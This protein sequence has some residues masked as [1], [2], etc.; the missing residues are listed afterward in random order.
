MALS[1]KDRKGVALIAAVVLALAAIVAT[2]LAVGTAPKPGPDGCVGAVVANTVVVLDHTETQ[3]EQTRTEVVARVLAHVRDKTQVNER[4]SVFTVSELSKKSLTP[5][6]SRCKPAE[7]GNR[8]VQNVSALKKA[9]D[10]D[11]LHPLRS[12]LSIPP[13]SGKE[14]PIA[15]ALIDLSLTQYLRGERNSLLVFSDFLEHTPKFTLYTCADS[16]RAVA[17]LR[18]SRRGAQERPKFS[19]VFVQLNVIPRQ[20]ISRA[21]LKCRDQVWAWFFGDNEGAGARFEPDYLPGA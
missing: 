13:R 4:V 17:A 8:A 18:D 19:N 9:Y 2:K 12:V 15:Q 7:E 1:D 21:T 20:D 14:S 11:F 6:F 10:R 3:T 5:A 16:Q